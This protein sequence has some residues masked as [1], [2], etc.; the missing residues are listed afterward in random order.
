MAFILLSFFFGGVGARLLLWLMMLGIV[1]PWVNQHYNRGAC[2][3]RL[4]LRQGLR[5]HL[6]LV[7]NSVGSPG[8]LELETVVPLQ[9]IGIQAWHLA[10]SRASDHPF[11]PSTR[12]AEASR[13]SVSS[14]PA[15]SAEW[16]TGQPGPHRNPV[17]KTKINKQKGLG[18]L[19]VLCALLSFHMKFLFQTKCTWDYLCVE[20]VALW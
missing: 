20:S 19:F 18:R 5:F 6:R 3:L 2:L 8:W 1:S 14:R 15:W 12:E 7:L 16:I 17:S 4:C 11:N 13:I 9:S 10:C